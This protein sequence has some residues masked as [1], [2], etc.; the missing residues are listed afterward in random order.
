M[1]SHPRPCALWPSFFSGGKS[2]TD[3]KGL[4]HWLLALVWSSSP[5]LWT[6]R[7]SGWGSRQDDPWERKVRIRWAAP[8]PVHHPG[9]LGIH[10][11]WVGSS[12]STGQG[13]CVH[14]S[15]DAVSSSVIARA[16]EEGRQWQEVASLRWFRT[17]ADEWGRVSP[18]FIETE[19]SSVILHPFWFFFTKYDLHIESAYIIGAQSTELFRNLNTSQNQK[20]SRSQKVPSTLKSLVCC[21]GRPQHYPSRWLLFCLQC[22]QLVACHSHPWALQLAELPWASNITALCFPV[23]LE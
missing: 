19:R 12:A 10:L 23:K 14:I 13:D 16:G 2:F 8:W 15:R 1:Y 20:Q 7:S 21:L 6:K 9:W 17:E 18:A 4:L 11:P 3:R 5:E 22:G